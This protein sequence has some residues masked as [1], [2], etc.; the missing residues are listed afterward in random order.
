VRYQG[1]AAIVTLKEPSDGSTTTVTLERMSDRHW[2]VVEIDLAKIDVQFSLAEVRER[3]EQLLAPETPKVTKP[4]L[5]VG[6]PGL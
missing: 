2:K 1:N 3:A 5:P 4:S 6:I